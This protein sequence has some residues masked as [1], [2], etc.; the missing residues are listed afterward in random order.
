MIE[1]DLDPNR[2]DHAVAL[3]RSVASAVP[4]VGGGIAEAISAMV[5]DQRVDRVVAYV[6]ELT[7]RL[8]QLDRQ[9]NG[10][11]SLTVDLLEDTVIQ[12]A[13]ALSQ[14]RNQYLASVMADSA[15][16]SPEQ[17]EFNKK[18][19]QIL[20]ELTDRD[21]D[22]L[23][24]H[25]DFTELHR[26]KQG[27]PWSE[28]MAIAERKSLEPDEKFERESR[29]ASFDVHVA[30]LE[31]FGLLVAEREQP[32]ESGR[33][34]E[35]GGPMVADVAHLDR[36]TGLPKIKSYKVTTLGRLLL[37]RILGTYFD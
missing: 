18:L 4:A 12:S 20:A 9:I 7:M 8:D 33:I 26:L 36:D 27:W 15:D 14:Q 24:A 22:I 31:R 21:I 23:K 1:D 11:N 32:S 16:V 5:R 2:R 30:T 25:T 10:D 13:R 29:R 37:T 6:R 17:Y 3:V 35:H 19:L 34:V 28:P